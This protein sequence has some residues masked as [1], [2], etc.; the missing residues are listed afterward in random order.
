MLWLFAGSIGL[1]M[2]AGTY[3]VLRAHSFSV[4]L[5][6]MLLTYATNLFV[7]ASGGLQVGRAPVQVQTP[8][9]TGGHALERMADP[10]PQA[11]VLTAIVI[12]FAMTALVLVLVL[13]VL[14]E[15][16]SERVDAQPI[17]TAPDEPQAGEEEP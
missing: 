3:L 7:F 15:L 5:G 9:Q 4:V 11:L 13:R 1:L 12:G 8:A 17:D 16:G 2:G 14:S 10:L 6:L